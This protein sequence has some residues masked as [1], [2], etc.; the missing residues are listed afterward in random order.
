MNQRQNISSGSAREPILGYSR[1]VR[2]G[3]QIVVAGTTAGSSN[4]AVGGNDAAA[5]AREILDRI[6]TAL[7]QAGGSFA[8]VVRTG[9]FLTNIADFDAV[10]AVHGQIFGDIRPV[11]AVVEVGALAAD[12][13]LVEIEADAILQ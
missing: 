13:L 1:A 6:E 9:V 3:N 2:V 8:D 7:I 11:T 4:G 5:Q 10:G 12:D